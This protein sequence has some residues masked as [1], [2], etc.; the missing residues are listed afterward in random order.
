[1]ARFATARNHPG[2][3]L[4]IKIVVGGDVI[5]YC[6]RAVRRSFGAL[7]NTSASQ[8]AGQQRAA[9]STCVNRSRCQAGVQGTRIIILFAPKTPWHT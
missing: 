6:G 3:G 2:Y 5:G 1:L 7:N 4:R 9:A 8:H